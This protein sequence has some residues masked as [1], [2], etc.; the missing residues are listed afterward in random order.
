MAAEEASTFYIRQNKE[1]RDNKIKKEKY[2]NYYYDD[3]EDEKAKCLIRMEKRLND[4]VTVL[5]EIN[6]NTRNIRQTDA[7]ILVGMLTQI[8]LA[9]EPGQ[10][11]ATSSTLVHNGP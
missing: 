7:E 6:L 8:H 4:I 1:Y 9:R 2:A 3:P 10:T 5:Q 11:K